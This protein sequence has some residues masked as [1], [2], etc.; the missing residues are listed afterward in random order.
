MGISHELGAK[1]PFCPIVGSE[2]FS[3][4]VKKTEVLTCALRRAIGLFFVFC[5]FFCFV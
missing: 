1:V 4:E 3:T 2:L 5:F